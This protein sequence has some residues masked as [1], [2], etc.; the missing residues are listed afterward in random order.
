[1]QKPMPPFASDNVAAVFARYPPL[2]R[3]NMIA[4][5]NLIFEIAESIDGVGPIEETLKW[6]EP[7]Y[8]TSKTKTGS[9]IRIDWKAATP[10]SY[11]LFFNCKTDLVKRFRHLFPDV[12]WF[13]DNRCISFGNEDPM[14]VAQLSKCIQL[15]LTYHLH[16]RL[17]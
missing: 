13:V 12:F 2:H 7:S 14:P 1:M 6:G 3:G 8:L 4:L 10:T 16:K 9:T 17:R 5:R 11:L 15:A